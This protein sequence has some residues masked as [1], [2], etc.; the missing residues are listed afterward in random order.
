VVTGD[1][2][3][4]TSTDEPATSALLWTDRPILV[5][6][7][8]DSIGCEAVDKVDGLI[9]KDEKVALG[10]KAFRTVRMHP[11]HA[12]KD[13]LLAGAGSE[14]P[15]MLLVDP[16]A[17][18]E[19]DEK[20]TVLE[21]GKLK[22]SALYD[23]MEKVANGFWNE[24]LDKVVKAHLDV[25]KDQDQLANA[26]KVL[27]EKKARLAEEEKPSKKDQEKLEEELKELQAERKAL[28]ERRAALWQLTPKAA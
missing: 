26:E 15:R 23:A 11:D 22:T 18:R 19:G 25:L 20:V 16:G 24:K 12:A 17:G 9:L 2:A 28:D 3:K 21:K 27:S 1:E 5:Y 13:P 8:D 10:T 4:E 6:V 7:C 14:M